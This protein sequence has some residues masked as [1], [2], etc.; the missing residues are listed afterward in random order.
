MTGMRSCRKLPSFQLLTKCWL[1]SFNDSSIHLQ[2]LEVRLGYEYML[3]GFLNQMEYL[4]VF[5]LVYHDNVV[6]SSGFITFNYYFPQGGMNLIN[7]ITGGI[8]YLNMDGVGTFFNW[9]LFSSFQSFSCLSL[10]SNLCFLCQKFLWIFQNSRP[11]SLVSIL[12]TLP[13]GKAFIPIM[14]VLLVSL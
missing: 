9:P 5:S 14:I 6:A 11:I 4:E 2:V 13:F 3:D 10:L 8:R 1:A 12:T 7:P